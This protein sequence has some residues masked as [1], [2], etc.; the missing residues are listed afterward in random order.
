[1]QKVAS[2]KYIKSSRTPV[3]Q[4]DLVDLA[5]IGKRFM[6][7]TGGSDTTQKA[8][9]ALVAKKGAATAIAGGAGLVAPISTVATLGANRVFQRGINSNQALVN[10]ALRKSGQA[11]MQ[12]PNAGP[13][14]ALAGT[15]AA[16]LPNRR[17]P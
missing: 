10:L 8:A 2:N 3:G 15:Q 6:P 12:L 4:D 5:R 9:L 7:K 13:L 1:M 14:A 16:T 17:M 11:A